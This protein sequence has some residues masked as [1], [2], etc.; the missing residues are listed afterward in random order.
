MA[1]AT[2]STIETIQNSSDLLWVLLCKVEDREMTPA[3]A[4]KLLS[5][6][7]RVIFWE[8]VADMD[9]R[10][11]QTVRAE[12]T[13]RSTFDPAACVESRFES[14]ILARQESDT[15]TA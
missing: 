14:M 9:R 1:T 15:F 2:D 11:A 3:A 4:H 6:D 8:E 7:D 13:K 10:Y 5:A 12:E